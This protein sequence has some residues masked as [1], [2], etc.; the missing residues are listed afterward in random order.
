MRLTG[1][2]LAVNFTPNNTTNF[3][4]VTASVQINV[5]KATPGISW[6][7]P[8]DIDYGTALGNTQLNATAQFNGNSLPGTFVYTPSAGTVLNAGNQQLLSAS[9]TPTDTVNFNGRTGS[10]QINVLKA[11]PQI[12]WPD[13]ADYSFTA[14]R[15]ATRNST[16]TAQF[17]GSGLAGA[18][19][20]T[21]AAGTMLNAGPPSG[22]VNELHAD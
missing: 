15:S 12:I 14:R 8:A 1:Q 9:F 18:F 21:P 19:A 2:T 20:Y 11:T 4:T 13:P 6:G 22:V 17:N 7:N 3:K 10:V 5:L 16:A